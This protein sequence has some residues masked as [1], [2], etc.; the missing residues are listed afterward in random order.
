MAPL[1]QA[2]YLELAHTPLGP[3]RNPHYNTNIF[4][5]PL[6]LAWELQL[7]NTPLGPKRIIKLMHFLGPPIPSL[8][9]RAQHLPLAAPARP[10]V[11]RYLQPYPS[12]NLHR[13]CFDT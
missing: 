6:F 12:S 13:A 7:A 11:P 9:V 1:F 2:W 10:Q 3:K 4:L 5:A 8:G